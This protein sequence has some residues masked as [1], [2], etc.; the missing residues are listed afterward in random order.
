MVSSGLG[1]RNALNS[2]AYICLD[3]TRV[4]YFISS[5]FKTVSSMWKQHKL[6]VLFIWIS[7]GFWRYWNAHKH[8]CLSELCINIKN[9]KLNFF[10][11]QNKTQLFIWVLTVNCSYSRT[12][13]L[14]DISNLWLQCIWRITFKTFPCKTL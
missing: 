4:Y 5:V 14:E 1:D 9:L 8:L 6:F 12:S 11:S 3:Y 7:N 13:F 2:W 10:P